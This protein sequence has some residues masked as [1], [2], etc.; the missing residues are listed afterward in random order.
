MPDQKLSKI[1]FLDELKEPRLGEKK[2]HMYKEA[3]LSLNQNDALCFYTD[4]IT[5]LENPDGTQWGEKKFIGAYSVIKIAL[6]I[7]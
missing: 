1:V 3:T 7:L 4:G 5:E 6:K 2:G